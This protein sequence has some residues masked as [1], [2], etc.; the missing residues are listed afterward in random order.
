MC[1]L[2]SWC[3]NL[4]MCMPFFDLVWMTRL[5]AA[6][7]FSVYFCA[8]CHLNSQLSHHLNTLRWDAHTCHCFGCW[9][10]DRK[11]SSMPADGLIDACRLCLLMDWCL[12]K[13]FAAFPRHWTTHLLR[14]QLTDYMGVGVDQTAS[15]SGLFASSSDWNDQ[16]TRRWINIL[17]AALI[18]NFSW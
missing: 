16:M 18:Y 13:S 11:L 10:T 15:R 1:C 3:L 2:Q 12:L 4:R 6:R 14:L 7:I 17:I 9:W 8:S 5:I